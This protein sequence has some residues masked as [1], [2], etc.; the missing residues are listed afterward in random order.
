M[1]NNNLQTK[2]NN[3]NEEVPQS[4]TVTEVT[5][6]IKQRIE[7]LGQ[8]WI[9]GEI[10]N[11]KKHGSG[12]IYLSL[13][14]NE[15]QI[16]AIIWKHVAK[17][18]EI[19][20]K[21][22]L[23]VLVSGKLSIYGAQ[24]KY[25]ISI[26]TIEPKGIGLLLIAYENLKKK[27]AQK[28]LFNKQ[29]KKKLPFLPKKICIITSPTGAAVQDILNV[30]NRRF[31]NINILIY[32]VRVQ[33]EGS[34]KEIAQAIEFVNNNFTCI[35]V[36]ITGRGGGSLEDLWAFNEEIVAQAIF[37]SNIPIISA[38]GHE[39]DTTISDL[40]ADC[41]ALTPSEAGELVVPRIDKIYEELTV[42]ERQLQAA[43]QKYLYIARSRLQSLA[44]HRGFARPYE[45]VK[46]LKQHLD[47]LKSRLN[48]SIDKK[49]HQSQILLSQ[50]GNRLLRLEPTARLQR[51]QQNLK[52]LKDRLDRAIEKRIEWDK[53]RLH[54]IESSL[55]A[56]S[57]LQV[58]K[59]GYSIAYIYDGKNVIRHHTQAQKGDLFWTRLSDSWILSQV[60]DTGS[61]SKRE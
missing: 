40:V 9:T 7:S 14:D 16:N 55:Q 21:D 19:E 49:F 23:E 8:V 17:K 43:I 59:R 37:K 56:L 32:P 36:I 39:V 52:N 31:P 27:L 61:K 2:K 47:I 33:G 13:K 54:K 15:N 35:D 57:P 29:Y 24:S 38:V 51:L 3:I 34:A 12:H 18:L 60:I 11:F 30:I 44:H 42:K 1:N 48:T 26:S 5:G 28:G 4:Y 10:S 25:Q 58:L 46:Q 45:Q 20:L 6:L 50:R 22:G 53:R 41:R